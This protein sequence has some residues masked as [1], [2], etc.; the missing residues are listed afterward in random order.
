MQAALAVHCKRRIMRENESGMTICES[1]R[2]N[3]E[4]DLPK[5]TRVVV[6]HPNTD[7]RVSLD[8]DQK[9]NDYQQQS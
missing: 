1:R 7:R 2:K 9:W 4:R 3:G 8:G 5:H 6:R